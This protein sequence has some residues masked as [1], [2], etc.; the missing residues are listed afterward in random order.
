MCYGTSSGTLT[1]LLHFG[2]AIAIFLINFITISGLVVLVQWWPPEDIYSQL[3]LCLYLTWPVLIFYNFFNAIFLGPGYVPKNWKPD[4]VEDEARLQFCS[5]CNSYKAPR[6]HHCRKCKRCVL[7]MDHHCPWINTCCGHANHASF[8]W[9]LFY[10]PLGCIHAVIVL[11]FGLYRAIFRNYYIYY[12][13]KEVPIVFLEV[14]GIIACMFAIGM[15]IGVTVAVGI[16]FFIQLK[17]IMRNMTGI[18]EWIMKKAVHRRQQMD[19]AK[20]FKF[21]YDLG[22]RENIKQVLNYRGN[23]RPIGDGIW[24]NLIDDCDQFTLTVNSHL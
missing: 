20:P 11:S 15:A 4:N 10:A 5:V 13:V 3:H 7:K 2:P 14:Y 8:F 21:P 23:F 18:E 22:R 12:N 16:L 1:Q 6:S 24:W 17:N 19:D 9:F